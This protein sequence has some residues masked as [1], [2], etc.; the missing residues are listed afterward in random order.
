[1]CG[2]FP[3]DLSQY[4]VGHGGQVSEN[5]DGRNAKGSDPLRRQPGITTGVPFGATAMIVAIDLDRKFRSVAVE[6]E[7]VGTQG[8]LS[9]KPISGQ[10]LAAQDLP[11]NHFR[12]GH[13]DA[14][15]ASPLDCDFWCVHLPPSGRYATCL[16][17]EGGE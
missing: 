14:Q 16:P 15:V 8:M 5:L 11:E 9:T 1:M 13:L 7:D 3:G 2:S 10:A 4:P 12:Q 6:V 17:P